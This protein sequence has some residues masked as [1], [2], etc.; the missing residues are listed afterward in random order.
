[1]ERTG[2][3]ATDINIKMTEW[4]CKTFFFLLIYK[5]NFSLD[6]NIFPA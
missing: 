4:S 2:T 5:F 3:G 6:S 1:M